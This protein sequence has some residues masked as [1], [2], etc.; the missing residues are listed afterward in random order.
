LNSCSRL[1]R[2][3][4]TRP[5]SPVS[6]ITKLTMTISASQVFAGSFVDNKAHSPQIATNSLLNLSIEDSG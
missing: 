5:D 3:I 1:E 4:C 2:R 6:G